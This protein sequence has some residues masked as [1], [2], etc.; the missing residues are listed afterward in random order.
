[1]RKW[2]NQKAG[3]NTRTIV[4][5]KHFE[6]RRNRDVAKKVIGKGN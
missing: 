5:G 6:G 1:M 4:G 3:V 2:E